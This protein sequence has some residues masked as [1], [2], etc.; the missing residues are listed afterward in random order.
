VSWTT[1]PPA[2]RHIVGSILFGLGWGVADACPG[3]I[4]TQLGQ[5]IAWGLWALAGVVIGVAVFLRRER[6]QTQP[7]TDAAGAIGLAEGVHPAQG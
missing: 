7:A 4:P 5:G 6:P 1:D 3:P 2:R